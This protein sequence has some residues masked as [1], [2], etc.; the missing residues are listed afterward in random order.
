MLARQGMERSRYSPILVQKRR[1]L[2][3][4]LQVSAVMFHKTRPQAM[5]TVVMVHKTR[6][7]ALTTLELSVLLELLELSVRWSLPGGHVWT[8]LVI[9]ESLQKS[10]CAVCC[11]V[12]RIFV[13]FVVRSARF[14]TTRPNVCL[15]P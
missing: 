5:S 13:C 12:Q 9:F 10:E 6:T 15:D 4:D 7:Q 2:R 11:S 14:E 1:Q 3:A 8:P